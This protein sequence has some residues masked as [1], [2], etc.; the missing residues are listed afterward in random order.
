[1]HDRCN[2]N[3]SERKSPGSIKNLN[4]TETEFCHITKLQWSNPMDSLN[5]SSTIEYNISLTPTSN[6]TCDGETNCIIS[7]N[8]YDLTMMY[9][10]DYNFSVSACNCAGCGPT[11]SAY[12][13]KIN[14]TEEGIPD[15][16]C[17]HAYYYNYYTEVKFISYR[18]SKSF[19][20][21]KCN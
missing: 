12:N 18:C 9:G 3:P 1:M 19:A 6:E 20:N 4:E 17:I 14:M 15:F 7:N 2:L 11:A 13:L 10:V 16:M 5:P 21:S 8:H